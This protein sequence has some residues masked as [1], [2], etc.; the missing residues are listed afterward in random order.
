MID[1]VK[2][3]SS[4][5]RLGHWLTLRMVSSELHLYR[6]TDHQV[7]TR[8]LGMRKCAPRWFQRTSGVSNWRDLCLDLLYRLEREPEFL[9]RVIKVMNRMFWSMTSRQNANVGS[10]ILQTGSGRW[11]TA[12]WQWAVEHCKLTVVSGTMPTDSRHWHTANWQWAV[13]HCKLTVGIGT[14]Q[15]DSRQWHTANWQSALAH[16]KLT[17]GSDTL[18]TDSRHW[19]TANWQ[20]AVAHCKLS[21]SQENENEQIENQTDGYLLFWQSGIVYKDFVSQ[22]KLSIILFIRK[23]WKGWGKGWHVRP[24]TPHTWMPHHKTAPCHTAVSINEFLA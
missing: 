16:C 13:A 3:G 5:V 9:S 14:L 1:I 20:R 10:G 7:L 23:S 17:V 8:D 6:F 21:P 2:R 19:H 4:F 24:D 11:H 12:N 15:T 22:Y 18:Q